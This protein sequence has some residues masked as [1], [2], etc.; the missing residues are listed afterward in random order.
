LVFTYRDDVSG[1][2]YHHILDHEEIK[3]WAALLLGWSCLFSFLWNTPKVEEK[4]EDQKKDLQLL[5]I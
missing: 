5:F 4:A 3:G 2:R 1:F